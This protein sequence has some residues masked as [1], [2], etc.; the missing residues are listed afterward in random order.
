MG[1]SPWVWSLP[2]SRTTVRR[3]SAHGNLCVSLVSKAIRR[4]IQVR[5]T[6]AHR[7][8]SVL[9]MDLLLAHD[10]NRTTD[11]H[12]WV[13]RP[14]RT[15]LFDER[16]RTGPMRGPAGHGSYQTGLF[17]E[18]MVADALTGAGWRIL[19]HRVR[20]RVGEVDLVARRGDTIVFCEVKT[21]GPGRM[22]V[23]DAVSERGRHRIRRAAVA[24]MAMSPSL[25]RGVRRYRFDVFL[26][27]RDEAGAIIRIDQLRD[28]F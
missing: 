18:E 22:A 8:V 7:G 2:W 15:V 16:G 3:E 26:V 25:Q 9:A 24:W 10:T 5:P 11:R 13:R 4:R 1:R 12:R 20:T 6:C 28:A 27:R 17:G 23:E 14:R 19:G 21:A